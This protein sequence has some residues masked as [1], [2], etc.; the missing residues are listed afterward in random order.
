MF[1]LRQLRYFVA[2]AELE[3]VGRAASGLNMSQSPLSRQILDLEAKLGLSLFHRSKRRLKLTPV[4]REFLSDAKQL[5]ANAERL[6]Q[7]VEAMRG[8]RSGTLLVG[9]VDGAIHAELISSALNSQDERVRAI[10]LKLL[11]MRS[12]EQFEKL[13]TGEIDIALTYAKPSNE[14]IVSTKIYSEPY[15]L[16]APKSLNLE[17]DYQPEQ[18]DGQNF[19]WLPEKTY[20]D[21][22]TEFVQICESIGF[23]PKGHIEALSPLAALELVNAGLALAIVQASLKKI[24]LDNVSFH[25]LPTAPSKEISIY[26]SHRG[27]PTPIEAVFLSAMSCGAK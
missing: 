26:L 20:P 7:K 9:Y 22:K 5:L 17:D 3:H 14:N 4:G 13:A 25:T 2:V 12:R 16:A 11:P 24:E 23:K 18:L 6:S 15:I 1:D 8:G 19:A 21:A 10:D 27:Q